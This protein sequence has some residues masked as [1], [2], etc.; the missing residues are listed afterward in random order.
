MISSRK[1]LRR[2]GA[3]F[4]VAAFFF[5]SAILRLAL[6]V[7]P[8]VAREAQAVA[9]VQHGETAEA[10]VSADE[11]PQN[12]QP[13][14]GPTKDDLESLFRELQAREATAHMRERQ[15][16]DR[17]KALEVAESAIE[18]KMA[19]LIDAENA[20]KDTLALADGA[21]EADLSRLTAVY[22]KMKPKDA[23][24]VFETM[25]P[26]FAAGFLAR[27]KP[28]AAAGILAGLTPQAA[29]TVSV[30]LAGRNATVPKN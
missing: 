21:S 17:M 24:A 11:G 30:I 23:S 7:G 8:A 12:E 13:R 2:I 16:E 26:A 5:G 20:L 28:E 15:I 29:Y 9:A 10:S 27:M 18:A 19:A 4:C 25:D 3:L 1:P 14:N 6:E 22:E